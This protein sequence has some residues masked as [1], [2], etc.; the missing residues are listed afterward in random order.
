MW[1]VSWDCDESEAVFKYGR[2]KSNRQVSKF[3]GLLIL[4]Y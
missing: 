2:I 3:C 4:F 1:F